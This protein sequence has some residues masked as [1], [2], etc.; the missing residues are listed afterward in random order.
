[1]SDRRTDRVFK[2]LADKTRRRMLDLLANRPRT[3]GELADAF[4][5]L[6][7]FAV[8]KHL[9]VLAR[10]N[11]V[12]AH[13]EGRKRWNSLN[14]VPLRDVLRRWVGK[15]EELWADVMLNIRD[16]AEAASDEIKKS[17]GEKS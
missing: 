4:P 10:A 2:A 14:P 5:G 11:L 12:I 3:T 9:G 13:R 16:A 1:V 15:Y 7:R 8:M 17:K 6:S